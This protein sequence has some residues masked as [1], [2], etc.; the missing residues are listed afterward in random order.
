[1]KAIDIMA[2]T[3]LIIL[4]GCKHEYCMPISKNVENIDGQIKE[5]RYKINSYD[6]CDYIEG[7]ENIVDFIWHDARHGKA[8]LKEYLYSNEKSVRYFALLALL[9]IGDE[10]S[11]LILVNW[12][13]KY[14]EIDPTLVAVLNARLVEN[15]E[16]RLMKSVYGIST[17][18]LGKFALHQW[19]SMARKKMMVRE[20]P[21]NYDRIKEIY[22]DTMN[23]IMKMINENPLL[24]R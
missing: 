15:N 12:G 17:E 21:D 7:P 5:G 4:C 16:F 11:K 1:M 22:R 10:E 19:L 18:K 3:F 8:K 14:I 24:E 20:L 23:H 6:G 2:G 9:Q 13:W